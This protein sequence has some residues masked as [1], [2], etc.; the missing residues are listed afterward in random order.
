MINFDLL[1]LTAF[2]KEQSSFFCGAR[3]FKIQQPTRRELILS[4][5]KNGETRQL[6]IN[7]N[8]SFYHICFMNKETAAKRLIEIPQN[9]PMFC[10]L[11]RK[12][13]ENSKIFKVEMPKN[14]RIFEIYTESYNEIGDKILL[15]LAIE[16]MG[17]HSNIVLYNYDTNIIIGCAHNV[18][19]EKSRERELAGTLPYIYPPKQNKMSILDYNGDVD[20]SNLSSDFYMFSGAFASLCK[21]QSLETLKKYVLLENI[22]PAISEDYE[23]YSLF[24]ELL[25]NSS[26]ECSSV[27]EMIDNY[28]SHHISLYKFKSLKSHYKSLTEQKLKKVLK[29]LNQTHKRKNILADSAKYR[30]Y[31]DL[32]M[33]N[34]YTLKDYSKEVS[35]YDYENEKNIIIALDETRTIKDNANKFYKLYNKAKTSLSKLLEMEAFYTEQ[36]TYLEQILYSIDCAGNI[37]DLFEVSSEVEE[38]DLRKSKASKNHMDIITMV[39]S[40]DSKIY[41]GKNNKQ[42][43]YIISKLSSDEDL[44]FH[45]HNCAGSHVLLKSQN[46]TD[47]LILKCARLAKEYSTAKSSSKIGV[48]YTKRKYLRKPP[49]THLGYV[50]YKNEKEI[51]ID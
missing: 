27:N 32:L 46:P 20:Y 47:E 26:I 23:K 9:P 42:N 8:P 11:L 35:V 5:R 12:Y 44:W 25:P 41:I 19:A 40:D 36:K 28:Y 29:S 45:V 10:M 15:C 50:T 18:G 31:G 38:G 22:S 4:L 39:E 2:W 14:E 1:T 34:L 7:I 48:I 21:G 33:A 16:L 43:D 51:V 17:K 6:Y 24:S 30:L 37:E 49:G 3:I 13:L